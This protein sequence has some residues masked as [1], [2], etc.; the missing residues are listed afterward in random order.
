MGSIIDRKG[1][2]RTYIAMLFLYGL[3]GGSGL[4]IDSFWGILISRACLGIG[5]T[6]FFTG[7]NVLILDTFEGTER[8]K[9]MGWRGSAQS[10]GGIIWPLLG[11][12][13]LCVMAPPICRTH[14]GYP[15]RY[16][17]RLLEPTLQSF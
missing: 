17:G 16:S 3:A 8:D 15:N 12:P 5:L 9:V 11:G 7:I 10:F 14:S 2:K 6:G 4:L 13:G 1:V